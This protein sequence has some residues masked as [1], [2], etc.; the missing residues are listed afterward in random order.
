MPRRSG[1]ASRPR[2]PARR[3][4]AMAIPTLPAAW[5]VDPAIARRERQAIFARNWLLLGPEAGLESAGSWRAEE[6]YGWPVV[7]IRGGDGVLRGFHNA[8]RHRGAA[9]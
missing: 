4:R 6:V 9:L 5:Y 7:V 8:C 1:G 2:A 3:S